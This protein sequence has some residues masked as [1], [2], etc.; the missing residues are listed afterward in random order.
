M[1]DEQTA[2]AI[3]ETEDNGGILWI[4]LVDGDGQIKRFSA[5]AR[6]IGTIGSTGTFRLSLRYP[7]HTAVVDW[8]E[9]IEGY[10]SIHCVHVVT[11]P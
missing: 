5:Y 4:Q 3:P 6:G 9:L 1:M 7:W 8:V 11:A 2:E 10:G